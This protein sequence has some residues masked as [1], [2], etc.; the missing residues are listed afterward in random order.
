VAD[1]LTGPPAPFSAG[2]GEPFRFV[3]EEGKVHEFARATR[4][5]CSEHL[6]ALDPVAPLTFLT[7]SQL[8][9]G[10]EHSAWRGVERDF[11]SVLH[12]EQEY[13]FRHGPLQAGDELTARQFVDRTYEK[14]GRRGG[15]MEFTEVVTRFWRDREDDPVA[16]MR[17]VSIRVATPPAASDAVGASTSDDTAPENGDVPLTV[18][19]FV[20][21]QGAS[22]DFNPIH[23]DPDFA[24]AAGYS[25]PFA[26]GMLAAGIAANRVSERVGTAA[27]T[28]LR[29]RW[30]AQA[31]P[32]DA[33]GYEVSQSPSEVSVR[34]L[35]PDGS[36]HLTALAVL[37]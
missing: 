35:R 37:G 6:R 7:A 22:G 13:V 15:S 12:G 3:V 4:S 2:H 23:H 28:R 36:V 29:V 34:V 24:R 11:R 25:G 19:D 26:V 5:R 16:D 9:M 20:R 27:V 33:L 17:S 8:W 31:W 32:G 21:Y 10:P 1:P 30:Q 14:Q 18:T